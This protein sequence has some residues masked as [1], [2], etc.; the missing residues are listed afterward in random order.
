VPSPISARASLIVGPSEESDPI[1]GVVEAHLEAWAR[2][3]EIDDSD[4]EAFEEAGRTADAAMAALMNTPP[5][6]V[7][8]MRTII[9]YLVNR[10]HNCG[11]HYLPTLLRSPTFSA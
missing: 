4:R 1:F 5:T 9:E 3:M 8:G 7:A 2:L 11:Y 6:T 10:D